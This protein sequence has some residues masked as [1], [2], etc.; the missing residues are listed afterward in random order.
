MKT[1][2]RTIILLAFLMIV[3]CKKQ[4]PSSGSEAEVAVAGAPQDPKLNSGDEVRAAAKDQSLPPYIRES[5]ATFELV[6]TGTRYDHKACEQAIRELRANRNERTYR[7]WLSMLLAGEA[8]L[9]DE[10]PSIQVL[11]ELEKKAR[12]GDLKDAESNP[13]RFL[14][15]IVLAVT[16]LT[17]F[18]MPQADSEVKSFLLRFEK[19]YGNSEAGIKFIKRCKGEI[20]N[21]E[22]ARSAGSAYWKRGRAEFHQAQ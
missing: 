16:Y 6:L 18:D 14:D 7:I 20:Q 19:K 17:E 11:G 12:T 8:G 21:A 10:F 1:S 2:K 5:A 15:V 22:A 3:G 4:H 9:P 13:L